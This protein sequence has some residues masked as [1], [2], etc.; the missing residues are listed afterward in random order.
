[1]LGPQHGPPRGVRGAAAGR[2]G[3]VG[4]AAALHAAAVRGLHAAGQVRNAHCC[5]IADITDIEVDK[6]VCNSK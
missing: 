4:R 1:M 2:A 5:I 3:A 6:N